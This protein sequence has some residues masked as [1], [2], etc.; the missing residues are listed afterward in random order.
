MA[1]RFVRK[2]SEEPNVT[3]GD[4]AR[5]LRYAY[6]NQKGYVIGRGSE[7]DYETGASFT[8]KS[9][10]LVIDGYSLVIDA[11]GV[12]IEIDTVSTNRFYSVWYE[13]NLAL[14]KGEIKASYSTSTY[15]AVASGD[16]L[17]V[18]PTG[19]ARL[20]IYRFT[21]QNGVISN[22][23]KRVN[24]IKYLTNGTFPNVNVGFATNSTNAVNA[25]NSTNAV[26]TDLTNTSWTEGSSGS[27]TLPS[28]GTYQIR[29]GLRNY[30][31]IDV[32]SGQLT[33]TTSAF[34]SAG[35]GLVAYYIEFSS[36]RTATVYRF[37]ATNNQGAT[38]FTPE[39]LSSA[40]KFYYRKIR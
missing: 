4:D 37:W 30:G 32:K 8:V 16:D 20:E 12:D 40:N 21:A 9:G 26:N 22:V 25:T 29:E 15:P 28:D 39:A 1:S 33:R 7:I 23:S 24:S 3:S 34:S 35:A 2:A 5:A 18:N 36:A 10:E 27:T 38:L 31:L 11:S 17:T 19:I 14:D 6:G 13:V